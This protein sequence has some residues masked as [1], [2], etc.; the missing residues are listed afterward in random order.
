MATSFQNL[1]E[2]EAR[3]TQLLQGVI[4]SVCDSL[5]VEV[6]ADTEEDTPGNSFVRRMTA[7]GCLIREKIRGGLHHG[8]KRAM[9]VIRSGFK[10]D[11]GLIIDGFISDP[12]R[13][14]EENEA[15]CLELIEA[16][17]EPGGHLVKLFEVE[18]VPPADDEGM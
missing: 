2:A 10:Y 3:W 12:D 16:A 7:L 6:D 15:A 4:T 5:G 9:E 14:D 18:V 17:E 1:F 8:V 13:T 11:M